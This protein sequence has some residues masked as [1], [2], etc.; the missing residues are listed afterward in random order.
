MRVSNIGAAS[1]V[2]QNR[3]PVAVE[4]DRQVVMMSL[5]Q[6]KYYGLEGAGGRIWQLADR[7]RTVAEICVELTREFEV[8]PETCLHDVCEFVGQLARENLIRIVEPA[9]DPV[10]PTPVG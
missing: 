3:E 4:V 8:E 9:T 1:V 6:G 10:H 2:V 7:P 5:E